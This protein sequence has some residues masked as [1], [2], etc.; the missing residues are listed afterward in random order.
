MVYFIGFIFFPDFL[1]GEERFDPMSKKYFIAYILPPLLSFT[2]F[3]I[4][5]LFAIAH[6][7]DSFEINSDGIIYYTLVIFMI[8]MSILMFIVGYGLQGGCMI[9]SSILICLCSRSYKKRKI[10]NR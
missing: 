2:P 6:I 5:S 4:G 8:S 9:I 10:F 3:M 1:L 7:A